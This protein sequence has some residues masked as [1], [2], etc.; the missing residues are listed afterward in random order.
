MMMKH[1]IPFTSEDLER[2]TPQRFDLTKPNE[3]DREDESAVFAE[4][5]E[6]CSDPNLWNDIAADYVILGIPE[7][8]GVRANMGRA[9]AASAWKEFL[10]VFLRLPHNS[11]NDATRFCVLGEVQTIDLMEHCASLD[12][13]IHADRVRL[14]DTVMLL[15]QRVSE[16][17]HA[18]KETGKTPIII[19]GG[20]NN[21]YPILRAY[22]YSK[23]IDCINIDAHTDLRLSKGRHSGNGFTHALENGYLGRYFMIGIQENAL[24]AGMIQAINNQEAIDYAPLHNDSNLIAFQVERALKH[25][26]D[27]HYGL[28]ID[29]DVIAD[30]PSSAQSPVGYSFT[31]LQQIYKQLL[32]Q[33]FVLP[34]YIHF[35]EAAP[36]YGYP[37][38]VGKALSALVAMLP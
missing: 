1:F 24:S 9:G 13:A 15:D 4:K 38:Q 18:I 7:D 21:C 6:I 5:V 8:I 29:L 34:K 17:I 37:N 3:L 22:G 35:C 28:E 12:P 2:Y 11:I 31:E 14:S 23:A 19:G 26:D 33:A 32:D 20:H 27:T 25:I 10:N 30:F 36:D 16:I